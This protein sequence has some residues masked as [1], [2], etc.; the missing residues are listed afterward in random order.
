VSPSALN[1]PSRSKKCHRAAPSATSLA[2]DPLGETHR[3]PSCPVTPPHRPRT[4]AADR[5]T[6]EPPV[7]PGHPCHRA[8]SGHGDHAARA[9]AG[10]GQS[11]HR[12]VAMDC[13]NRLPPILGPSREW[14]ATPNRVPP[15]AKSRLGTMHPISNLSISFTFPEIRLN[16]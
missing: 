15:W 14:A 10:T 9:P 8:D 7:S 13:V 5:A 12:C 16:F 6:C 1:A 2:L 3:H 11:G 4:R